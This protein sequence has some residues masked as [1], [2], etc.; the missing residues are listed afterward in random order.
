ML[1]VVVSVLAM[2]CK[3]MRQLLTM[4]GHA[5]HRWKDTTHNALETR[6][7]AHAWPQQCWK[8]SANGNIVAL[9]FGDQGT[10]LKKFGELLTQKFDRVKTLRNNSQQHATTSKNMQQGVQTDVCLC[11]RFFFLLIDMNTWQWDTNMCFESLRW[12]QCS[13]FDSQLLDRTQ[14]CWELLANN[15]A[16]FPRGQEFANKEAICQVFRSPRAI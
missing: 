3:Q 6:C 13:R 11:F 14:Q 7:N 1:G 9:S 16:S 5:V 15:V 12:G 8:S 2:V 4:L 10:N